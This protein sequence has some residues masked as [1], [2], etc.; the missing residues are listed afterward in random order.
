MLS[1]FFIKLSATENIYTVIQQVLTTPY[2]NT[3]AYN[4]MELCYISV[5]T[6][7]VYI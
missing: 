4:E 3:V 1:L 5:C 7:S 2:L 6:H